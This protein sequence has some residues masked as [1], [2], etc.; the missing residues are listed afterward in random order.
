MKLDGKWIEV[1]IE[2]DARQLIILALA[3]LAVERP[4][5]K[6][7]LEKLADTGFVGK[8]EFDAFFEMH[9]KTVQKPF[10]SL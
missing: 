7:T 6:N 2:E 9:A 5:W 4:G 1:R 10:K 3:H 8:E